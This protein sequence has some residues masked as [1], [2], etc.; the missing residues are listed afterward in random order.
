MPSSAFGSSPSRDMRRATSRALRP[1]S[2]STLVPLATSSTALPVEPLPS[3]EIFISGDSTTETSHRGAETQ[4]KSKEDYRRLDDDF[5]DRYQLLPPGC[6]DLNF[7]VS[8]CLCGNFKFPS[9]PGPRKSHSSC[10]ARP[11]PG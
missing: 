7:S 8:Q 5:D 1:A 9:V 3:T 11:A 10:P 6:L 2:T 4:R